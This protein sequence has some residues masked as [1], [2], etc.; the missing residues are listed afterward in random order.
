MID[1]YRYTVEWSEEDNCYIA[2]CTEL[3]YLLAF[4]DTQEEALAEI[5]SAVDGALQ[6]LKKDRCEVP[7]PLSSRSFRGKILLRVSAD[8]HKKLSYKSIEADQSLNNFII[9]L[10]EKAL[11]ISDLEQKIDK[12]SKE[13]IAFKTIFE[14]MIDNCIFQ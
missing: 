4:G 5:K 3:D 9:L 1:K 10:I 2:T 7:A 6:L 8:L 12:N 14:K 11:S 13:I